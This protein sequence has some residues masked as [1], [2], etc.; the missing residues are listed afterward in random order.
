MTLWPKQS[1]KRFIFI[2]GLVG[3]WNDRDMPIGNWGR[4]IG[5]LVHDGKRCFQML[6]ARIKV[7]RS[8]IGVFRDLELEVGRDFAE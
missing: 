6:G 1:L 8:R 4:V 2:P 7:F 5:C 3:I